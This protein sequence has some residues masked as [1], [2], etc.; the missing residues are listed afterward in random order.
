MIR[1]KLLST[2][3]LSLLF[4]TESVLAQDTIRINGSNTLGD[5]IVPVLVEAWMKKFGYGQVTTT[6]PKTG[7]KMVSAKRDSDLLEIEI[8]GK[9]SRSGFQDLVNGDAEIAMMSRPLSAKEIDDG[10]QLGNLNSPDQEHVIALQAITAIVHP[11]NQITGLD[12]SQLTKI[13]SGDITDWKQLGG[14]PGAIRV[15]IARQETGL[16]EMQATILNSTAATGNARRHR[17]SNEIRIAIA[18]DSNAIGITEFSTSAG[19]FRALPIRVGNRLIPA[20]QLHIKTEDYPLTRRLYFYTGQIVTALGR[21]FVTYAESEEGQRLL[22]AHGFL[23]LAPMLTPATKEKNLPAEYMQWVDGASRMSLSFRFGNAFS[24]FDSRGAQ[25]L[26]RLKDFMQRPEN[27]NRKVILIGHA[28]KQS[29]L[30]MAN[31]VSNEYADLV[32]TSLTEIGISPMRVRG[33]GYSLP[34]SFTNNAVYRNRRVDVWL[35]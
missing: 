12:L 13:I 14:K 22:A 7:L 19:T 32:A 33:V 9:G 29:S 11:S 25:D 20:D 30:Y 2:F 21:G 26:A 28:D 24:I 1:Q 18:A 34:L 4:F 5:R 8:L 3:L 16:A 15:H 17:D 6:R 35:R 31:S 23:S 27:R 10:W